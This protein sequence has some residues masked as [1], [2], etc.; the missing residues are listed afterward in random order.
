V[1]L[2]SPYFLKYNYI[3][4]IVKDF[5]LE[6]PIEIFRKKYNTLFWNCLW[7]FSIMELPFDFMMPYKHEIDIL[8]Y[9]EKEN[10]QSNSNLLHRQIN[11]YL[12]PKRKKSDKLHIITNDSLLIISPENKKEQPHFKY[13]YNEDFSGNL[14]IQSK[15]V[16][17]FIEQNRIVSCYNSNKS[18][19]IIF[20]NLFDPAMSFINAGNLAG[21]S[22][23]E[24]NSLQNDKL[25][26]V[27]I[28]R[29]YKVH[30]ENIVKKRRELLRQKIGFQSLDLTKKKVYQLNTIDEPQEE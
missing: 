10:L 9:E 5:G 28:K 22:G 2:H 15:V 16:E 29:K 7:Y 19:E 8:E 23:S 6:L 1:I 11:P 25:S 17:I 21:D 13:E 24:R 20:E 12:S 26:E 30:T 18:N 27:G 14:E 4:V 3:P